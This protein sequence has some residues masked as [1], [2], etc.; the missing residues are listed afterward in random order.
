ML[1]TSLELLQMFGSADLFWSVKARA[2]SLP[3]GRC[4][5][6][7]SSSSGVPLPAGQRSKVMFWTVVVC[8]TFFSSG[9]MKESFIKEHLVKEGI[10][11]KSFHGGFFT[12]C[13]FLKRL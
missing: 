11:N 7:L 3:E 13:S 1:T 6:H 9:F 12:K 2:G 4:E 8:E 5:F 10:K